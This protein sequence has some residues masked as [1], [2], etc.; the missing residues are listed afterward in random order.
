MT[1]RERALER[2]MKVAPHLPHA[3]TVVNELV[4]AY[5][6]VEAA[7]DALGTLGWSVG[8]ESPPARGIRDA[9]TRFNETTVS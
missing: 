2:L 6:V 5:E 4:A 8:E 3:G 7:S 1:P 9:L